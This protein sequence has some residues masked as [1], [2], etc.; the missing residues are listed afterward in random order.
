MPTEECEEREL[1]AF[2][3][4]RLANFK[5][6]QAV[7]VPRRDPEEPAR[8]DP[9]EVPGLASPRAPA[10]GA[11]LPGCETGYLKVCRARRRAL[12]GPA[13]TRPGY[14]SSMQG[15]DAVKTLLIDNYDS[16]TYNLFQLLAE[17]NGDEPIVVRNDEASWEELRAA[18]TST[19]SS[20]PRGPGSP[21]HEGDFGV[22]ADAIRERRG[23]AAR[24]LPRP[25][26][27][28]LVTA[29]E[30][31]HAPEVMHGRLSA[32][33]H[34]DSPLFAGIPREFQAVRYHSLCVEQPLP[35]EL[36]PIAWTSDGVLMA[37][38][39]PHAA[40]VGRAVPPR[41]DLHR[42]R[43]PAARQL[44]RP[45][46]RA[47]RAAQ[48]RAAGAALAA[49]AAE[50]RAR[51]VAAAARRSCGCRSSGSTRLYD[52][53]RAFVQPLRRQPRRLL[54]RQ[55]QGRRARALL[56]H[57]RRRRP[58]RLGD[59]LRRRPSGEVRV[60]RGGETEVLQESIFDYLEPRDAPR[61]AT[62]PTTCPST[63][64]AASSATS[65]TS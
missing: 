27:P 21:D 20:S 45:D 12:S 44:P 1:I 5:V 62:S 36:E 51:A 29:A 39:A 18:A 28:R 24:R 11:G 7:E 32:V 10:S 19:T 65:A 47:C 60:E 14:L 38:R 8:Q 31:V 56:V 9:A 63:S 42:V 16:F 33:L 64:T 54:A 3:R 26:G 43:P 57:G 59:H 4:E 30:V 17:A 25:P 34:D 15:V 46:R 35:D 13:A 48:R 6:P 58:A 40:A 41:V 50:L 61:C 49:P 2:C 55:Q 52:T 53:E 23:A 22:C 37:R